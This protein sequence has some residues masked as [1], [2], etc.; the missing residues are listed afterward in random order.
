MCAAL[1]LGAKAEA[2]E[3]CNTEIAL[4]QFVIEAF[5]Y[6]NH[7]M[8]KDFPQLFIYQQQQQQL[9][10]LI[11]NSYNSR[12]L[13]SLQQQ[14][15]RNSASV[16]GSANKFS[17]S[18]TIGQ[19][20]Q[21]QQQNENVSD[22]VSVVGVI[23][24]I[25]RENTAIGGTLN[26]DQS[27]TTNVANQSIENNNNNES[28]PTRSADS[29]QQQ[30][31]HQG[32]RR[33][34]SPAGTSGPAISVT[35][36]HHHHHR[37]SLTTSSSS[38]FLSANEIRCGLHSGQV[39]GCVLGQERLSFDCLGGSVNQASRCMSTSDRGETTMTLRFYQRLVAQQK[40]LSVLDSSSSS[41]FSQSELSFKLLQSA[42]GEDKS[43]SVMKT[44]EM[45]GLGSVEVFVIRNDKI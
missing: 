29:R 26:P 4:Y 36:H 33:G 11:N 22:Q 6:L 32:R 2:D 34:D 27:S 31:H 5:Y 45:K 35:Q 44:R 25:R 9:N 28:D 43:H 13:S 37:D 1:P 20:Q 3:N 14:Q 15:G 23:A 39:I 40:K 41:S 42:S 17:T 7:T 30:P 12:L 10:V 21:Q 24:P 16:S 19:E 18:A 8:Q 38:P